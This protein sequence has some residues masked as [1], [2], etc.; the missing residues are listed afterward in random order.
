MVLLRHFARQAIQGIIP[1]FQG[2]RQSI[3]LARQTIDRPACL[4][5]RLYRSLS[6]RQRPFQQ[7]GLDCQLLLQRRL[8]LRHGCHDVGLLLLNGQ[9]TIIGA[10]KRKKFSIPCLQR[11]DRRRQIVR[12]PGVLL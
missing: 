9:R 5:L 1:V 4:F 6:V 3:Q 7:L 12:K 11:R 10:L 8:V 2:L